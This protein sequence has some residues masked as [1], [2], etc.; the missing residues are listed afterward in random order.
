LERL[1][2]EPGEGETLGIIGGA[3]VGASARLYTDVA[4]RYRVIRGHL[5]RIVLWNAP[6]SD[7]LEH[8]FV[9]GEPDGEEA[10]AAELLVAQAVE[11]LLDAGAT[12]IA[13]PCNSLQRAAAREAARRGA[14]FIDM[15]A[16]T[17]D[18]VSGSGH[19]SAVLLS[20][21]ATRA[22]RIY[23]GRG[24]EIL[25]PPAQLREEL[26]ALIGRVVEGSTPGGAELQSLVARATRPSAGVVIGCTDICGLLDSGRGSAAGVV[27]SLACLATS[28]VEVLT[29]GASIAAYPA[30]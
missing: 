17:L 20:T 28:C 26:A 2:S 4:A 7:A 9:G 3:G 6:F 30:A 15:I 29:G 24:V 19:G 18:G 10:A 5:P 13:M 1:V 22:A 25:T 11:R 21:E 16:A 27:D 14:P 8:A 12:V 23:E